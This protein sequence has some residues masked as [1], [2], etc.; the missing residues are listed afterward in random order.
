[1]F[2]V[3]LAG[4]YNEPRTWLDT[5]HGD[6]FQK[7]DAYFPYTLYMDHDSE[8]F[9]IWTQRTWMRRWTWGAGYVIAGILVAFLMHSLMLKCSH[10]RHDIP[11]RAVCAVEG[12]ASVETEHEFR[13]GAKL[14]LARARPPQ[15]HR[16]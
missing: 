9:P 1:M 6:P 2:R 8:A 10:G 15:Y 4:D 11:Y 3:D 13:Q 12:E 16:F 14:L 7:D 5:M